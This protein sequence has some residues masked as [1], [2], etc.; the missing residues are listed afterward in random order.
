MAGALA[1]K[2]FGKIP[3]KSPSRVSRLIP[4]SRKL[5]EWIR[6]RGRRLPK[7]YIRIPKQW[8]DSEAQFAVQRITANMWQSDA[9]R[10]ASL[11]IMFGG[12]FGLLYLTTSGAPV[13]TRLHIFI[14]IAGGAAVLHMAQRMVHKI[15]PDPNTCSFISQRFMLE[16]FPIQKSKN[17]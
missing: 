16:Q 12:G 10:I 6:P 5:A 13:P 1:G 4:R 7:G 9:L 14:P 15:G 8:L 17:C 11:P 3:E 2:N